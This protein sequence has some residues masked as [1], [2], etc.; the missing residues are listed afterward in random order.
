[1]PGGSWSLSQ[2]PEVASLDQPGQLRAS[3]SPAVKTRFDKGHATEVLDRCLICS[4][5]HLQTTNKVDGLK[6]LSLAEET[7]N[8]LVQVLV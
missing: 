2:G 6:T 8:V 7:R 4:D 3:Y 1:M 5:G